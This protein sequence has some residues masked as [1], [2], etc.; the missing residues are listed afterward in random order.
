MSKGLRELREDLLRFILVLKIRL[1]GRD[2]T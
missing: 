2:P 1:K